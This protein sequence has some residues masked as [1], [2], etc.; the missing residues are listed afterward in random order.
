MYRKRKSFVDKDCNN[1]TNQYVDRIMRSRSDDTDRVDKIV[2][3]KRN[4]TDYTF[5]QIYKGYNQPKR[6]V[7]TE[8]LVIAMPVYQGKQS[9]NRIV[10]LFIFGENRY[11]RGEYTQEIY[12]SYVI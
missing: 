4:A 12:D 7:T 9:E 10:T 6:E 1:Q 5:F 11:R 2:P 8:Y 3:K